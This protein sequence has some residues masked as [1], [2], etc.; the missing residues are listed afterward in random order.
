M[1]KF[2]SIVLLLLA[3]P[4]KSQ[5]WNSPANRLQVATFANLGTPTNG[6]IRYCSDCTQASPCAGGGTGAVA[7][8]VAAAWSCTAGGSGSTV[9][10]AAGSDVTSER[11]GTGTSLGSGGGDVVLGVNAA[12]AS[13]YTNNVIIGYNVP[14]NGGSQV[15]I[16]SAA[17]GGGGSASN[18]VQIGAGGG[19]NGTSTASVLVGFGSVN[20]GAA[21]G[22]AIG[23]STSNTGGNDS[24]LIGAGATTVTANECQ[25]GSAAHPINHLFLNAAAGYGVFHGLGYVVNGDATGTDYGIYRDVT[26]NFVGSCSFVDGAIGAPN[27]FIAS[28]FLAYGADATLTGA[29]GGRAGWANINKAQDAYLMFDTG[30]LNLFGTGTAGAIDLGLSRVAAG[31]AGVGNG[32]AS[33]TSAYLVDGGE[34]FVASDQTNATTTMQTTTCSFTVKNARKYA[35]K[36]EMFLSDSVAAD[37]AKIDFN[38]GS[39][40]MTNFRAQVTAFDTALNL[41]TQVSALNTASSAATFTG[42]GAF[43]I[44]GAIEPSAD[45]TFIPR[46]AQVAH[47]AGTLT[48][49]RGSHCTV[50][51]TP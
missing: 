27:G 32:T 48:L 15:I 17:G 47:T 11:W 10:Y 41:S 30:Q 13:T 42:A 34:C 6:N 29:F 22:T 2:L 44:H 45:G 28:K 40:T 39:A 51:D 9:P 43:E 50:K 4:A 24:I 16:G 46:F 14:A 49:A 21:F 1:K 3:F 8:R 7:T 25:I 23:Y 31:V 38:G 19:T 35:F 33:D 5:I 26:T 12:S 18:L 36:C 37:G 20:L